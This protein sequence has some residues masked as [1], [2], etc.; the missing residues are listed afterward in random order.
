[1]TEKKEI[2]K[3]QFCESKNPEGIWI[4]KNPI[5]LDCL[6][7]NKEQVIKKFHNGK[8]PEYEKEW[9]GTLKVE[10]LVKVNV[11]K[12]KKEKKPKLKLELI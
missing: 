10:K 7:S 5:C 12:K 3:C 8:I 2:I 1:M 4:N 9:T 6:T 11:K